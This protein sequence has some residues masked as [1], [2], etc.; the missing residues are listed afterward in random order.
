MDL[1]P[2]ILNQNIKRD[3]LAAEFAE[4]GRVQICDVFEAETAN[5]ILQMLQQKTAWSLAWQA[6]MDGP[7]YHR[8]SGDAALTQ[9]ELQAA[10]Q[11]SYASAGGDGYA[12][13]FGS[14]P[15]LQAYMEKWHPG[16]AHDYVLEH[17]NDR[18][19]LDLVRTVT[20]FS[21]LKKADAQATFYGP[22]HFLAAHDDSHVSQGWRVAYVLNMC[23]IDW[24]PD[25]GGYLNFF[26]DKGDILAGWKPRFNT[27][28]LFAVP[29]PHHVSYV[30]P[31]AP[32]ARFAIT[33][34]FRDK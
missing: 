11:R 3:Q 24:R 7:H 2:F 10:Q 4:N 14:Y 26:D 19:F 6:G 1:F 32:M 27:L 31:F 21:E 23:P 34:W 30:P 18:P 8:A 25:W 22:G 17:I 28:N 13:T 33:G 16:S 29:Q 9:A 15:M 5:G 20:N 12:F